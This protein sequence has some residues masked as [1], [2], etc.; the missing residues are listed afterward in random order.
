MSLHRITVTPAQLRQ[1]IFALP[2]VNLD[3]LLKMSEMAGT[4]PPRGRHLDQK[5]AL[6]MTIELLGLS[7][8]HELVKLHPQI[9]TIWMA[10]YE[11]YGWGPASLTPESE[12]KDL[13]AT[14]L[15][16][17]LKIIARARSASKL[18]AEQLLD[19]LMGELQLS[20]ELR[21]KL[22]QHLILDNKYAIAWSCWVS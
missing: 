17:S 8:V 15:A 13:Q 12:P 7:R 2:A 18:D 6:V 21:F 14:L 19:R 20:D 10:L 3:G 16:N 11:D 5:Q 4:A 22:I 1:Q 9:P